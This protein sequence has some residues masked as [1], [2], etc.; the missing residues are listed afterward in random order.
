MPKNYRMA[1][2]I[3]ILEVPEEPPAPELP[4]SEFP[5]PASADPVKRDESFNGEVLRLMR[6]SIESARRP[7]PFTA[8]I[9]RPPAEQIT[10]RRVYDLGAEALEDALAAAKTIEAA[11]ERV[12]TPTLAEMPSVPYQVG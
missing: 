1:I 3:A 2:T 7:G 5:P 8:A 12:G 4:H 11:A 9:L 6:E 10:L